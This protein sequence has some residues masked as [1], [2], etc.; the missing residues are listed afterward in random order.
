VKQIRKRITYA[1]VMSSIA[2]FLVLG[3]ASAYAAKKIGSNEIKGNSITTG[4]LKKNAVTASKI[5]SNSITTAKIK[6]GAV[7][8]PKVNVTTLGKVPSATTADTAGTAG[9]ANNVNG[10][11]AQKVFFVA[12]KNTGTTTIFSA[13]GLTLHASCDAAGDLNVTGSTSVDN[14]EI[15]ESGNYTS[16]YEGNYDDNFD[17]GD[18][19]NVGENIGDGTQEEVQGQLVYSTSAG[20]VVT[21]QF[22]LNDS[23]QAYGGN[24]QCSVAGIAFFS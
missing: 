14:S 18:T 22:S 2:V 12:G 17:V 16:T 5:K 20:A 7:T 21:I 24:N 8:G 4:K 23:E 6:N 1:N 3:G 11:H 9:T 13:A 19:E 15:Y 10:I